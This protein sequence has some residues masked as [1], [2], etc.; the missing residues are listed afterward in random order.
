MHTEKSRK[1]ISR[2]PSRKGS[3][4]VCDRIQIVC[5]S[6]VQS[7]YESISAAKAELYLHNREIQ[8]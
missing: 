5:G 3:E 7:I 6:V 2:T 1:K 8:E 4:E